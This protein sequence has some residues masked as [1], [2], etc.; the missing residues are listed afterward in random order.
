MTFND[1]T[2][3]WDTDTIPMKNVGISMKR[4]S[5]NLKYYSKNMNTIEGLLQNMG[6]YHIKLDADFQKLCTFPI[7]THG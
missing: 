6:Y 7:E 5:I 2:V 3:T 1:H 4:K